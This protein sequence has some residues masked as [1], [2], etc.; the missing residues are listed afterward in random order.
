M[1]TGEVESSMNIAA[2][3][4]DDIWTRQQAHLVLQP[5]A[6]AVSRSTV[7]MFMADLTLDDCP[8]VFANES[9]LK[10]TG[11][12]EKALLG[13]SPRLLH[14]DRAV[15]G[16][17]LARAA[18]GDAVSAEVVLKRRTGRGFDARLDISPILDSRGRPTTLFATIFDVSD[19]VEAER[20]LAAAQAL[21]EERVAE[22]TLALERALERT[23]LL[24]REVTHRTMNALALL[25]AIVAARGRR[26]R[27]PQEAELLADIAGRVRAIGGLQGLLDGVESETTGVELSDFLG[28]LLRD[29]ERPTEARILLT[30]AP[31]ARLAPRAALAL[32]LCLSE[33][34]LNAQKHGFPD[35]RDGTI[36]VA[37]ATEAGQITVTVEDDGV[38]LPDG[39][40]PG[41]SDGLGMR[42]IL[43]QTEKLGGRLSC[44]GRD[45]GGARFGITFPA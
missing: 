39:F 25:S 35:G 14:A 38:G 4:A 5:F 9:L 2:P 44:G 6:L 7:P 40:D 28:Q 16:R 32:A 36:R 37:A 42:V 31:H 34:V 10:L 23:E 18:A 41:A 45:G 11:W 12:S 13:R 17:L 1:Q 21:F 30:G 33:L 27:T 20:G 3:A 26:A 29:L 22:R 43:D 8:I 24:S 19:R 15:A